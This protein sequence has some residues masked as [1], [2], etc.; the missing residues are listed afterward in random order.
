MPIPPQNTGT[1]DVLATCSFTLEG[2]TYLAELRVVGFLPKHGPGT[3]PRW[4]VFDD[5]AGQHWTLEGTGAPD[6]AEGEVVARFLIHLRRTNRPAG[7]R[8]WMSPRRGR[9]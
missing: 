4:V 1:P 9:P 7:W 2:R 6:D 8:R 5:Q 3:N